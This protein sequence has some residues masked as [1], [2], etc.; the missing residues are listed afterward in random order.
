[1]AGA[2][3][4]AIFRAD[5]SSS[6]GG[7]HVVR[8]LTLA[9]HL[10]SSGWVIGFACTAETLTIV[11]SL[12]AHL[13]VLEVADGRSLD[14]AA[15]AQR[16]PSGCDVLIVDHYS[17]DARFETSCRGWAAS[18]VAI[19]DL[20][21]RHHDCDLL[22]D[23]TPARAASDYDNLTPAS[24]LVVTGPEYAL[25]RPEFEA[26]RR[27]TLSRRAAMERV[28][29]V[30]VS[31][32]LTDMHGR[33][34]LVART[35]L[36]MDAKF[37]IDV[38]IGAAAPSRTALERLAT[39][40]PRLSVYVD[41]PDMAKLMAAAD[42]AVGAG[43]TTSWER[44]CL[45]LPTVILTLAKN[46]QLLVAGLK[47]AGA[48]VLTLSAADHGTSDIIVHVGRLAN[49]GRLLRSM[50]AAAASLVDGRGSERAAMAIRGLLVG[51]DQ[52]GTRVRI[53]AATLRDS[54]QVWAW[55]NDRL[56]RANSR[57]SALIARSDHERW[58]A[59]KLDSRCD[60][61][62]IGVVQ[63]ESIGVVRF[64]GSA[65]AELEVSINV[66]PSKRGFGLGS[67]LL[68]AACATINDER[69]H[70][71]LIAYIRKENLQS[72]R[73]FE[74]CGFSQVASNDELLSYRRA[75]QSAVK[76]RDCG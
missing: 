36:G 62:L 30:L 64:D 51:H 11:P 68:A 70:V 52:A 42:I 22:I 43:G 37:S 67:K 17:L 47:N 72:Q 34:E 21:D 19:D 76:K 41:P 44:C 13:E 3:R 56:S 63:K 66:A 15:L 24:A 8:C 71:G 23:A 1:M 10:A 14:A 48:A 65:E 32:G 74:A 54:R 28:E 18:I 33:T 75:S 61:T 27:E 59:G 38:V 53:R 20:A 50:A 45:G 25:L 57:N 6:I 4:H 39:G 49:D 58:F 46:Q 12:A 2:R 9:K 31:L 35:L 16:W 69:P 5:A 40:E 29:R 26:M 73:V 55:R 60:A 7:G